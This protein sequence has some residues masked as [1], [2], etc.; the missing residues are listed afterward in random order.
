MGFNYTPLN[1][2]AGMEIKKGWKE[3]KGK[4]FKLGI[5]EK[6]SHSKRTKGERVSPHEGFIPKVF[7]QRLISFTSEIRNP[8]RV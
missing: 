5:Q 7:P 8:M 3:Q 2:N 1:E 6:T 4:D